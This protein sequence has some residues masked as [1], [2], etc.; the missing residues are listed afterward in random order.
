MAWLRWGGLAMVCGDGKP[1]EESHR[2]GQPHFKPLLHRPS[3]GK[4]SG[5]GQPQIDDDLL[6]A[7]GCHG[8][9]GPHL[10]SPRLQPG[11]EEVLDQ[12]RVREADADQEALVGHPHRLAGA[13]GLLAH[14]RFLVSNCSLM[15]RG[16]ERDRGADG[17]P[18]HDTQA[19]Q[20]GRFRRDG[21]LDLPG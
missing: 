15:R 14:P 20:W 7:E 5:S 13:F 3:G 21:R 9:V 6:G 8:G 1:G 4:V 2:L 19:A 10:L 12:G 11:P 18:A 16:L 17:N